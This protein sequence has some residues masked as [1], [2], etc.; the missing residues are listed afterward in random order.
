MYVFAEFWESFRIAIRALRVHKMRSALTTLGIVIGVVSVTLMATVVN[1][2]EK[3]FEQ[4]MATLGADV[5]YIEKWPWGMVR[6][7]WNYIN[8]PNMTADLADVIQDRS[9]FALAAVPVASTM[10][11]TVSR[12][13]QSLSGVQTLGATSSYPMVHQFG[14]ESG[15][16]FSEV[17]GR[18]GRRVCVIG[19]RVAEEMFTVGDPVGKE[20]NIGG[21]RYEIVGVFEKKGETAD[22]TGSADLQVVIPFDAFKRQFGMERRDLSVRVRLRGGV[23]VEDAKSEI[24]GILRVA[25]RLDAKESDNFEINEQQSLREQLAP[26]KTTIY[27]IGIGLTALSLLVGGIGVMNIMF[28]SVKERTREIGIR[29]AVGAPRRTILTQFLVEAIIVC[30]IG[31]AL[32][33]LLAL[34]LGLAVKMIL[35]STL[36]FAMVALA[37]GIC[38]VV[39]V[40]FGLAPAWTAAGEEPIDAL[41]YE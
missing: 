1:G 13:N 6:D 27:S 40:I 14:L 8:R 9:Q 41:R 38:V 34:P 24:T 22:A 16:F 5:L 11:G 12:G 17:E 31:G 10:R 2:I 3:D 36:D 19:A 7:W 20:L 33:V 18:A 35:P 28:V 4:D 15:R 30:L 23:D 39:G 25:R 29:K 26:V 32:G 21:T 37:F